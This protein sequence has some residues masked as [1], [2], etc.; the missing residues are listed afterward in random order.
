MSIHAASGRIASGKQNSAV[1]L[2]LRLLLGAVLVAMFWI[3]MPNTGSAGEWYGP[4]PS[5]TITE[6]TDTIFGGM[7]L[8]KR[9]VYCYF[10]DA[11][12]VTRY[13][14]NSSG[15]SVTAH[16]FPNLVTCEHASNGT[17]TCSAQVL[18]RC[19]VGEMNTSAGRCTV[20]TNL[21]FELSCKGG[22]GSCTAGN[23]VQIATGRKLE[24]TVDWT[25]GGTSPL[26]FKRHYSSLH[27]LGAA[28]PYSRLGMGWRSNFDSRA[29]Y[30]FSTG[31]S[32]P[33][34]AQSGD[35]IHIVLPDS[36]EYVFR[37]YLGVWNHALPRPHPSLAGSNYWDY[38]RKDMDVEL[39]L[40]TTSVELRTES[41]DRYIYDLEG[42]LTKIVFP[43]GYSQ[44]LSYSGN[45]NTKVTDSFGR[46]L[47]F[48]YWSTTDKARLL[49]SVTTNDGK[50]ISFD[51]LNP[52]AA[53]A[54]TGETVPY[55]EHSTLA[56]ESVVY[57]DNT[58]GTDADNPKLVYEYLQDP[59]FPY[60]LTGI[61]DERGVKFASWTYDSKG[62]AT[63]SQHSGGDGLTTFSYDDVNNKVT[64]TNALGQSTIYTY[65]RAFGVLQRLL[66]VEGV[67]TANTVASNTTYTY[68]ANGFR[69]Q[70]TDAEGRVTKWI[71]DTRGRPTST[72]EGF[73]T[74]VART[75]TTT[76]DATRPLPTQ[77]AAPGL[78]TN[79]A[80]NAASQITSL[81]QVDTT[82]TTLPYS[83]N[84][85]TRTTAFNYTSFT[86]P[87]PPAIGPSG[88]PL[89]DVALTLI[90][91]DAETGTTAGWTNTTGAI[92]IV[93]SCNGSKCFYGGT[94]AYSMAYQDI[95]IPG[96]NTAE[97]DAG[98][99]AVKFAWKQNSYQYSDRASVG[100]LFLNG[101]GTVIGSASDDVRAEYDWVQRE[102]T[103]P[104]PALTRTIRVQM[105]MDRE[106]GTNNDG[107]IDDVALTLVADGT[108]AAKPY[109]R[110]VNPGAHTGS[111][112]GWTVSAGT[113]I[114]AQDA[115]FYHFKETGS[116]YDSFYQ[117]LT[118]PTDRITE[119]DG[120]ARGLELQWMDV[121]TAFGYLVSVELAFLDNAD[122]PIAGSA[123]TSPPATSVNLWK[124]RLHYADIP[125][126]A[127]K[128]KIS[129]NFTQPTTHAGGGTFFTGLTA[130]MVGRSEPPAPV[131]ILTS[132]DGPLAGT[133][134]TV[135][136]QYDTLGNITQVTDEL[137]H[138]TQ[139]TSLNATGQPLTILD[140]N[141]IATD[142]AY[143]ARG[144]L[145]T[146]TVNPGANE[147]VTA[148]EYDLAG[149]ITKITAPDSSFLE[150]T[151][152]NAK[153]L[154]MVTNNV[155]ETI[156]YGYNANGDVTSTVVKSAAA[157][158][159][160]QQSALFDELGRLMRSIGA[161]SQQTNYGYDRT[162][163][164]VAVT[165]PRSNLYG[166]A[167]DALSR[168][169]R[170][171]DQESSQ[172]NLT[173]NAQDDVVAYSDPRA[174]STTYVRNGFGE[175]IEETSPD[176]GVTTYVRDLRGL[177]TQ[178]TD[179]R[180]IVANYANDNA[181]RVTSISYPA[182]S[183]ED[184][185]Y[186][187]D[188]VSGG[189]KGIGRL[190]SVTDQSGSTSM[191]YDALGRITGETRAIGSQSYTTTYAYDAAD[192]LTEITYPS[193]RIVTYARN[194]LGQVSSVVTQ[195]NSL[196]AYDTVA[197]GI[198]W[199]PMSDL[200]AGM[201]Y[202]NGLATTAGYDL[203]YRLTSLLLQDGATDISSLSYTYTDGMN[204]TAVNDNVTPANSVSLSYGPA[205]RLAT[206]NGAWGNASFT[207]DGV[208]NRLSDVNT[209]SAVTTTRLAA[210]DT[211]SNRITGM[212]ENSAAL[213]SYTY[214]NGGNI[215]TDT[216]P[217]EV[218]AFTYNA[219]NRP[220][221]VT[222]NTVAYATYGY[223]A[224]E[225]LVSRSTSAAGGP[226]GT[227]HYIH[228]L[229]GHII[230][231]AD[232]S[233]GATAREY[234][235]MAAN[236][237]TP[238]DLPIAVVDDV[239][240][241]PILLMVHTDHLG[242]PIIMTDGSKATV[243]AASYKPWGEPLSISG[244]KALNLRFP[245]QYFQIETNLTYNWHRHYDTTTGRYTQPDPLR[246]V[247]GPSIY[248]YAGNSP[249]METDRDGQKYN[250][251]HSGTPSKEQVE[252]NSQCAQECFDNYYGI[253]AGAAAVNA[254]TGPYISKPR[255]GIG[256]G[257]PS[258]SSTSA[259]ST[260]AGKLL[261]K[262]LPRSIARGLGRAAGPVSMGICLIDVLA[263]SA[264]TK[265]C[266]GN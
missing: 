64:V 13:T 168:L 14:I 1:G 102:R 159:V 221:S 45:I 126:G 61:Y 246:F 234:I 222:R 107:Y 66:S 202:G 99:R 52:G 227:V 160:K 249:F 22:G 105:M 19:F 220:A 143:D 259:A 128:V 135:S 232:A 26:T 109:L 200:L 188:S 247:D 211:V 197:N 63:S 71:R 122:Q 48:E 166:Y 7:E 205:N 146:T 83:T 219:R 34:Q 217:G 242:R 51:F 85:Q 10:P 121:T 106:N 167:Y 157:T 210:Y 108:T 155:G 129:V 183:A 2:G 16:T 204:L 89:S 123:S 195:T 50:K 94:S 46:T 4:C 57:P 68:D 101:A 218:F 28:P 118:L 214:D 165:D 235:W 40:T 95:A 151:W 142:L 254:A 173:R 201:T 103:A 114:A 240:T 86:A 223:N 236:D 76:W 248:A 180:G 138:T 70:A 49:K 92:G 158:V 189:N 130:R 198:T 154:T 174:L 250:G 38:Y 120:L 3:G 253:G 112:T 171:T 162:D 27:L 43:T 116:G 224:F 196:A 5:G 8:A 141:G 54:L 265:Q 104:V 225:Q 11:A 164:L 186:T 56:L 60:A 21:G 90:N 17:F 77:I 132:V 244:T 65:Q 72:T 62:R 216:R 9:R 206:A 187:Y 115:F 163:K 207:Y 24:T 258:G 79:I 93:A 134:D 169:F 80:Y 172:V 145:I 30:L 110:P 113:V 241:T 88:T 152:N 74:A 260:A 41:G 239:T 261:P 131:D 44:F 161:S 96:A 73:G 193:G 177:I 208:G 37:R 59:D 230:A 35:R 31:V 228:D 23:P 67:A 124:Q 213:R 191:A 226:T 6:Q 81:S 233:T 29:S 137:G 215:L 231:E 243:W 58:P 266:S 53:F 111:T 136:Y 139:I 178:V 252:K 156:E 133:G 237:N 39:T 182:A 55:A 144:R 25:S 36:N 82:T 255:T 263:I 229:S 32:N 140:Q 184:V 238:T 209:V 42:R 47:S 175:V 20:P 148:I 264:C 12:P 98:Q 84:G 147:A 125:A 153:R 179:G 212:T 192:H 119:I 33:T 199:K 170:E 78:T 91:P 87:S 69:T 256:G 194:S 245:G 97:I 149:Q 251:Y 262:G 127:R 176:A 15:T 117:T 75:T 257:G 185:T 150:Y 190:T 18:Y 100:V 203:D 181:G